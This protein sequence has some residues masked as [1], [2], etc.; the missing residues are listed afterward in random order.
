LVGD[1]VYLIDVKQDNNRLAYENA[2]LRAKAREL[3]QVRQDKARLTRLLG[4][5]ETIPNEA[6]SAVVTGKDT[7][8]FF[9]V[10]HLTLDNPGVTIRQNMPVL[11][12]EGTVGIVE[13]V[14]GDSVTVKLAV[15]AGFGVDVVVERTKARGFVRGTGDKSRYVVKVEYVQRSDEVAV[16]DL[17]LTSGMGCRF[18]PNLPV[19]RVKRLVKREFG[20]YQEVEAEPTVDFS[21]L[22]E[23]LIVLSNTKD[24][25]PEKGRRKR[26]QK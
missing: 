12:V 19:A 4:L 10:A 23:A 3:K 22:E 5:K 2:R 6:V 14:A 16:G 24:C 20:I 21:R 18:P 13:R 17:L 7:T 11:A 8:E 15:D 26:A 9:R 25:T 1:Y